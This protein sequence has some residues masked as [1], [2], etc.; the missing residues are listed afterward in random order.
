MT[1]V[2]DNKIV[3]VS[4]FII[5]CNEADRIAAAIKS[6]SGWVDEVIV[7]DSGSTDDTLKIAASLG[8]KTFENSWPGYGLQ[9]RFGEEQCK[10]DWI[11]CLDADEQITPSLKNEIENLFAGG[12]PADAGYIL[13]IRDLL[14]GET[15]LAPMAHT[16]FVL[17]LYNKNRAR[18]SD[19]PVHDSVIVHSGSTRT[20]THPALHRSFR[21]L[22]H[23]IEKLNSYSTVQAENLAAK[24]L[25]FA[26]LRLI[27]EF[28]TAFFKVYILRGYVLRGTRGFIYSVNYA[29]GRFVRVAK[30]WEK[31]TSAG[32][33]QA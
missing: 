17:R 4:V 19:S 26:L 14:P 32:S 33:P 15:T 20:L 12:M 9:R 24:K 18:Y 30:Y 28:P 29:F 27:I 11:L 8:A 31:L 7:I 2:T 13:Q 16:N 3:P 25:D 5:A 1:I 21:N 10:N 23:A 22:A 6:V